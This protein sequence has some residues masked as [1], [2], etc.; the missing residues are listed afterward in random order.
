V[1]HP[2]LFV[3]GTLRRGSPNKYADLLQA[4]AQFLGNA[5]MRG[6]LLQFANYPGAVLSDQPGEWV[7]GELYEL[8]NPSILS[9]LDKYEGSEF[10][11]VQ[12]TVSLD[13]GPAL[14]TWAYLVAHAHRRAAF[15]LL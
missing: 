1:D 3:Y 5:R 6:R 13:D 9:I 7:P 12:T 4:N 8:Q 2:R 14:E 15:T 10:K 11:R